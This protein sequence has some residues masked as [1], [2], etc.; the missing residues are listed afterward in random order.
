MTSVGDE[1]R[2]QDCA[3]ISG[4][5]ALARACPEPTPLKVLQT[6][7]GAH[8]PVGRAQ[9]RVLPE[10]VA[11][12]DRIGRAREDASRGV[13]EPVELDRSH[14]AAA[15][16]SLPGGVGRGPHTPG[17]FGKGLCVPA[18]VSVC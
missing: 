7:L 14:P 11:D 2:A 15:A 1:S 3:L 6:V 4:L 16:A 13:S 10:I 8:V 9:L 12:E 18:M 5:S 17:V